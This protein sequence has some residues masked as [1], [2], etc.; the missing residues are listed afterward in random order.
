MQAQMYDIMMRELGCTVPWLINKT[1]I[2]V[3]PD[4]RVKAFQLYQGNRRNQHLI[5]H[6]PCTFTNM[7]FGPPVTG[8]YLTWGQLV[9]YFRKSIK[10]L[11]QSMNL[12]FKI[13]GEQVTTEFRRYTLLS[14]VA[15]ISRH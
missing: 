13:C 15:E 3:E 7:Y 9:L 2:C 12:M 10:V 11:Y 14:M 5:C 1:N 4:K 8:P 6:S